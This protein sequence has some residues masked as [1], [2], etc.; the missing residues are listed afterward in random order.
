M[1]FL[2]GDSNGS[3]G[4][5]FGI[6]TLQDSDVHLHP[7]LNK[8]KKSPQSLFN[9]QAAANPQSRFTKKII[10]IHNHFIT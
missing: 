6:E 1:L 10:I 3:H 8:L 2:I 9:F 7:A 5:M 4:I